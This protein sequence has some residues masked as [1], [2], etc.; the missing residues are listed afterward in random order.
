MLRLLSRKTNGNVIDEL[1]A[2]KER[3]AL[4]EEVCGI[5]LWHATSR[6]DDHQAGDN[7]VIWSS[8][9][10]RLVGADMEA[11][12]PN[13]LE[14]FSERIHPDDISRVFGD[15]A[16]NLAHPTGDGRFRTTYR[17]RMKDGNYRWFRNTGGSRVLSGGQTVVSCG[18]LADV[19]EEVIAA[20]AAER[21][22]N[23][24]RQTIETIGQALAA[25]AAGDLTFRIT[26]L[27]LKTG[28]L[29]Q[30]FNEM[31]T[32]LEASIRQISV[33]VEEM[34]TETGILNR[35]AAELRSRA[36]QQ[37]S[38]IEET[39]S[40]LR[41]LT[42]TVKGSAESAAEMVDIT[43]DAKTWAEQSS[44][45]VKEAIDAMAAIR[46]ASDQIGQIIG[47]IDE[48]AFQTNLLAL[49][50]GVEAARAGEAGKGFAVVAQ[51]VRELAQR[52]ARA[53]KEIKSLVNN[54]SHQVA[55]GVSLVG[56]TGSALTTIAGRISEISTHST[57]FA[58]SSREQ[59]TGI[60]EIG[61]AVNNVDQITQ[62]NA[63]MAEKTDGATR[64]MMAQMS[65][66]RRLVAHFRISLERNERA[67]R[68]AA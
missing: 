52:S 10:R 66:L 50:A 25:L 56:K 62:K 24:D 57:T 13:R 34:A 67:D 26:N 61:N 23:E 43:A 42:A 28:R 45:V 63:E 46:G 20:Q 9:V 36:E 19:H 39:S 1:V 21:I 3:T 16:D 17:L 53:A 6:V 12:F 32:K 55:R 37:A 64:T 5:G 65:G 68:R 18:S 58:V 60:S 51:E 8:E 49:N 11:E 44:G 48:I 54:S 22:A 14:S 30:D 41:E 40:A 38:A 33:A 31:A 15:Y 2:L 29:K 4:M 35:S 47:V 7:T 59:S 27:P